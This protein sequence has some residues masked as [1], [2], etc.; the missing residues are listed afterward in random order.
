M[1]ISLAKAWLQAKT[2]A[3]HDATNRIVI[4]KTPLMDITNRSN[5]FV[6][7]SHSFLKFNTYVN[8]TREAL[9]LS[10]HAPQKIARVKPHLQRKLNA[11]VIALRAIDIL[12]LAPNKLCTQHHILT[13]SM[14]QID[15]R[16]LALCKLRT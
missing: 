7:M 5:T 9:L 8:D 1:G 15:L 2:K 16:N 3:K 4:F 13:G 11:V 14:Q 10:S 12:T 6:V